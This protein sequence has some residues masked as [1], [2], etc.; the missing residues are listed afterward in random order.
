MKKGIKKEDI[1]KAFE[2]L[3]FVFDNAAFTVAKKHLRNKFRSDSKISL[4]DFKF[5]V[6]TLMTQVL[7]RR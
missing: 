6:S 5:F 1:S 3:D 7:K 2:E 4:L